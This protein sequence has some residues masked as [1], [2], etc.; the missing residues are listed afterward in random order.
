MI[1]MSDLTR[2]FTLKPE[3]TFLNFGSFGAC[4]KEIQEDLFAWQRE[5]ESE[6]VQFIAKNGV[7]YVKKSLAA[8]AE[9]IGCGEKDL[10][11]VP[12]PTHAMNIVANSFRLIP[13]DEVLSTNLEYGA[14]DRTWNYHCK[15]HGATYVR[16]KINLPVVSEDQVVADFWKGYT[17]R[18]KAIFISHITSATGL[19]LP[20]E[21]IC[22]EAK[23]K[24]LITIVDGAHVPGHIPLDLS[25]LQADIYTGA[26]HKWM[27]TAKGSSFLYV[28]PSMQLQ[29][30]PLIVSWGYESLH[31]SDSQYFDY[32]QFNGTRD[33]SA[34][35]TIP[36]AIA[37]M[38][39]HNW[40]AVAAQCRKLAQENLPRF[41]E[42][43]GSYALAPISDT[44]FGQMCS[45]P[46]K[47][48]NAMQL[49]QTLFDAYQIEIPVFDFDGKQYI[50]YSINAFNSQADLDKLYAALTELKGKGMILDFA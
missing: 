48:P 50:R 13:G 3:I 20:V 12:N 40:P 30:D 16:Q 19:I 1:A 21:R 8:L 9:Y 49:Q 34:Y 22:R 2:E 6:P 5:L 35:L 37:F 42:L 44:Y 14:I 26:C 15:K 39:Q 7:T 28:K 47:T 31:P 38:Q 24:G 32:H 29:F 46:I 11:F 4:P 27:M 41:V 10:V 33:F 23:E 36:K 25:N 18:T 17:H 43:L 45:I